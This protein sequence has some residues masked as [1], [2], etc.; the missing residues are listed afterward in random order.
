LN[1][2]SASKS[3]SGASAPSIFR[4]RQA[5]ENSLCET[6]VVPSQDRWNDFGYRILADIGLRNPSG[7]LEWLGAHFAI[8]GEKNL[9]EAVIQWVPDG[10]SGLPLSELGK[11]F[12][13]LM[14]DAKHYSLAGRAIGHEEARRRLIAL[15]D[16]A[17]LDAEGK[18]VPG[19]KD[20]FSSEVFA[21]SMIR[22]SE[23][24]FALR[25]GAAALAGRPIYG[26]DARQ[27]FSVTLGRPP[28]ADLEFNFEFDRD[29]ALRGRIAVIIGPNGSGKTFSLSRLAH[30][31]ADVRSRSS[32]GSEPRDV[33]Q[34]L[35]FAHTGSLKLFRPSRRDTTYV[36]VRAFALDPLAS[37]KQQR[38]ESDT[39]LLIDIARAH[40]M[41]GPSLTY[42]TNILKEEFP[43]LH[44]R[45]P[46]KRESGVHAPLVPP[47]ATEY[48]PL[49]NLMNGGEQR[50]LEAA[51]EIDP[52]KKLEYL[53]EDQKRWRPSLGQL[54]FLRFVL[55]A[56][57]HAGPASVFLVDEP[58]N[59]LHPNLISRFMRVLNRVLENTRS[60]AILA[61][62]SPF[63]VREVQNAQVHVI[64]E[65]DGRPT[66]SKPLMQTLGAN[67]ASISN[68]VF[69][70]DLPEHLYEEIL[71]RTE[72]NNRS[73]EEV[74]DRYASE[75]ST[76]ALMLLRKRMETGS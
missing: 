53:G 48:V 67:V 72:T 59:F 18:D 35:A 55:T 51:A 62:H 43:T 40:D 47:G 42:L 71:S 12:A 27:P 24:Y 8:E 44:I 65:D 13:S 33:N 34:V 70:D 7:G 29:N 66:I 31:L 73:F 26:V 23:S 76:E 37:R 16:A 36:R 46:V 68:Q 2:K 58:E 20:F 32:S 22:S 41:N 3:H 19:W 11:P 25:H 45:V 28:G 52:T 15:N 61:T 1:E 75:L 39:R 56:L 5:A 21:M 54:T 50:R 74:L 57:A 10:D 30:W 17:L 14:N 9:L 64:T 6:V 38:R 69:G 49:E 63:V 60:I 4:S